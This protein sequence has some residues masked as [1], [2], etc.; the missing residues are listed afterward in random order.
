MI[1]E[2][3]FE[4]RFMHIPELIRMGAHAEIETIPLSVTALSS[5]LARR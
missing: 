3:I 4:N 5:F 2:T 1:T